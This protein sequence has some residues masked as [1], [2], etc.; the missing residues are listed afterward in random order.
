MLST[1][2]KLDSFIQR[3]VD[4]AAFAVI[5]A[6]GVRKSFVHYVLC[7]AGLGCLIGDTCF[8]IRDPL[9]KAVALALCL[10]ILI[11]NEAG[12]RFAELAENRGMI[13][14]TPDG[15]LKVLK[16]MWLCWTI[17]DGARG[18]WFAVAADLLMLTSQYVAMTPNN[19]PPKQQTSSKL[20][21]VGA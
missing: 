6:F 9:A 10:L 11:G 7:R 13:G 12:R 5:R 19:P 21:E 16:A 4:Q 3:C 8:R 17:L 14:W 2:S 1:I 20:A 18:W 15:V